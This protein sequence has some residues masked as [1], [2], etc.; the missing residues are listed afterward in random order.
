MLYKT[1]KPVIVVANKYDK[2]QTGIES[3]EYLS[4][5]FGQA[6]M[7]SS[8]HGIGIGDLLD[9]VVN[10]MPKNQITNQDQITKIAIIGKPNVGKSSLINS[11]VGQERMIVSDLAGTT[12]DAVDTKF[13]YHQ[14]DYLLIDTAGIRKKAKV[15]QGIEKYSYLRSLTTIN[16]SDIVLLMIDASSPITDQD[17]NIGGL[18]FEEK[19]PI[20][21]V[22]NKW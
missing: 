13:K 9:K 18:A 6:I 21:I 15:Y 20:I 19:K 16:N 17:T 8:T 1:K 11:L 5:G 10:L 2:K 14:K 22:A 4:L 7:I 3:Y 12:L